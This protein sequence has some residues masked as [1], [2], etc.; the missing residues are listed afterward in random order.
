MGKCSKHHDKE[1]FSICNG[2]GK[3]FCE[4]CLVEGA[5]YYYCMNDECQK[6]L[7]NIFLFY[8]SI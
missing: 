1:A 4:K 8:Y 6:L 3:E 2:C 5:E 7:N